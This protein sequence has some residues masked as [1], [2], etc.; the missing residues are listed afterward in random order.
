[1]INP[2]FTKSFISDVDTSDLRIAAVL[3]QITEDGECVVAYTNCTLS[4]SER[5]YCVTKKEM[6]ALV[7][8]VYFRH[9][10]SGTQFTARTDHGINKVTIGQDFRMMFVFIME[11]VKNVPKGKIRIRLPGRHCKSSQVDMR[12]KESL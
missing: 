9:H 11:V 10:L 12:W 1:M 6:L 5:R 4:K 3:S 7:Y 8:F 2:G